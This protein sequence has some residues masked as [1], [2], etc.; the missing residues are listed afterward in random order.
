MRTLARISTMRCAAVLTVG[1]GVLGFGC[2]P[3]DKKAE[4]RVVMAS[5]KALRDSDRRDTTGRARLIDALAAHAPKDDAALAARDACVEAYRLGSR[6]QELIDSVERV[7]KSAQQPGKA[8]LDAL[9]EATTLLDKSVDVMPACDRAVTRL[10][11]TY[12]L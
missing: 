8:E 5:I 9:E 12:D 10:R 3:S 11:V 2:G 6:A 1:I 4:A 7:T